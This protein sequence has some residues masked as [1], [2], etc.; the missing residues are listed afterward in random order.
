MSV[1]MEPAAFAALVM[2]TCPKCAAGQ[3]VEQR[4]ATGEWVHSENRGT[5]FTTTL[6]MASYLRNSD[7]AP[8]PEK[9]AHG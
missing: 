9:P 1:R 8:L 2:S 6:C 5:T 4:L 7:Y 3:K